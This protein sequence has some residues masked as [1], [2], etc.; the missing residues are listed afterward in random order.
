M[1]ASARVYFNKRSVLLGVI[2]LVGLFFRLHNLGGE[3][4]WLDEASSVKYA[5][6]NFFHI[7]SQ[8]KETPPLYYI[9]LHWWIRFFGISEVSVRLPSAIFGF[10]SIFMMYKIGKQLFD[11][12]TGIISA[13]LM[14]FSG[15]HIYYSQEARTYSLSV[16]LTVMSMYFF[17][18]LF[19]KM[20]HK[21]L[22]G[23]MLSSLL[24]IYSHIYGLFIIIAQNIYFISRW[25]LV[26][27]D[28]RPNVKKWIFIQSL[29]ILLF[30]PWVGILLGVAARVEKGYW[31]QTP[32]ISTLISTFL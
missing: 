6:L 19:D 23:Y 29:L 17:I 26:H 11:D 25:F 24:L 12:N 9:F 28:R 10:F 18:S 16:L 15:F 27:E 22:L 20:S 7:F 21:R 5:Q 13:F 8:Y 2:L 31:L 3:S 4:L 14:A 30:T 1:T 32:H